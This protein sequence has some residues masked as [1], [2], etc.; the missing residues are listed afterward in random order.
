MR[1]RRKFW[2]Q[3]VLVMAFSMGAALTAEAGQASPWVDEGVWKAKAAGK[4]LYGGK[5]LLLGWTELITEPDESM[6]GG[7]SVTAGIFRGVWNAVGQTLGGAAQVLTFPYTSLD[8]PLPEGLKT[9]NAYLPEFTYVTAGK[10]FNVSGVL[11]AQSLLP[12]CIFDEDSAFTTL[13]IHS[14]DTNGSAEFF[15]SSNSELFI[16]V[17]NTV[18]SSLQKKFGKSSIYFNGTDAWLQPATDSLP[19]PGPRGFE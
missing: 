8:I 16:I 14:D 2:M 4:L 9:L 10:R 12:E 13:L 5:N 19:T 11:V 15:D 1:F 6:W 17:T 18:H 3:A 7:T